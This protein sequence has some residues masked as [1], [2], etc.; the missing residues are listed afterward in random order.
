MEKIFSYIT[1]NLISVLGI[2]ILTGTTLTTSALGVMKVANNFDKVKLEVPEV[3]E[4]EANVPSLVSPTPKNSGTPQQ[5]T[6]AISHPKGTTAVKTSVAGGGAVIPT[7]VPSSSSVSSQA[8]TVGCTITLFGKQ[9]DVT[10]LRNTHSGGNIFNCGTDMTGTYQARHGTDLSRMQ[11]YLISSSGGTTSSNVG[12]STSSGSQSGNG[13]SSSQTP[14]VTVHHK[15]DDEGD[16]AEERE[17]NN[18]DHEDEVRVHTE[19]YL[20]MLLK[21]IIS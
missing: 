10:N 20:Q 7:S 14:P 21:L 9:Y 2:T 8:S 17:I 12:S 3:R 11:Q 15:D 1:K 13:S 4:A 5:G 16:H 6:G 18:E 19:S